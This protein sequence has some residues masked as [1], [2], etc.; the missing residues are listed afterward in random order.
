MMSCP[1][2]LRLR[3]A[4]V[5]AAASL[6]G[7]TAAEAS[8]AESPPA[9]FGDGLCAITQGTCGAPPMIA[10][11]SAFP[12]E[13]APLVER[14]TVRE[15]VRV[16]DRVLRVGTLGDV[17]VVLGLLGIGLVN[18]ANTTKLVLDRFDVDALVISGV[19]GS[20]QRIGDVTAP[21]TWVEDDGASHPA[22]PA[23]LAIAREVA[24]DPS[25]TFEK[26]TPY[27][28]AN[29]DQTVCLGFDPQ[30]V[31]GGTG[32]SSDPFHGQPFACVPG[33]NDVFGCDVATGTTAS[34]RG[35]VS[36]S[37]ATDEPEA[38]D[39]ETA[40]VAR[41][42][43]A[44]GVPFIA[45]RAVSDGAGDPLNL[46]GFPTQF[47]AYYRLAA[48]NAAAVTTAFVTRWGEGRKLGRA[49]K[50]RPLEV[51]A[52]C[53]WERLATPACSVRRHAPRPVSATVDRC[54]RLLAETDVDSAAVSR[55]WQHAARLA[56]AAHGPLGR[57]C[58]TDLSAALLE[59]A[60]P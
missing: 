34:V 24:A 30:L 8:P 17:P 50:P 20:P 42:T 18:A 59:R 48:D 14:A 15:T 19:A 28:L 3:L 4:A 56:R 13:L 47:F 38:S 55:A 51:G 5:L 46:P 57:T 9:R 58:A 49:G 36:P 2:P 52:S 39:M 11:L 16:G 32:Q 10:V 35:V 26:C 40:A 45:F 60:G 12:A 33:G 22:D 53:D 7:S 37:A 6:A 44:R 1:T 54:C 21:D 23:L 31:V 41:E 43:Q 27:P 29:P 25:V